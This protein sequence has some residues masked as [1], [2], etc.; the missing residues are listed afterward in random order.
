MNNHFYGDTSNLGA[1][2][3]AVSVQGLG[4]ADTSYPW[5][6]RNDA[7][8]QLQLR[9]NTT[10]IE[11]DMCQLLADGEMGPRTCGAMLWMDENAARLGTTA[12]MVSVCLNP[13]ETPISPKSC[14]NGQPQGPAPV[15]L[16]EVKPKKKAEIPIWVW[17]LGIG[18]IAVGVAMAMKKKR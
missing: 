13:P 7:T 12:P 1:P 5:R 4:A 16:E 10:L 9:L 11:N 15:V 2:Y 3:D 6:V 14:P 18:V 17:G 8:L